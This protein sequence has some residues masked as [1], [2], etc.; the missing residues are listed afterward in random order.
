MNVIFHDTTFGSASL[1]YWSDSSY[2]VFNDFF[3][4]AYLLVEFVFFSFNGLKDAVN[5][6][7]KP[8]I[9]VSF[10]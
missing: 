8:M 4:S 5:N 2:F 6:L 3:F 9:G 10:S 7:R 1:A